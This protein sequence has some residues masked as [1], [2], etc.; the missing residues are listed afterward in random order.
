[1]RTFLPDDPPEPPLVD[2]QHVLDAATAAGSDPGSASNSLSAETNAGGDGRDG[3]SGK[4]SDAAAICARETI[5][6]HT[7]QPTPGTAMAGSNGG[8]S[9][10]DN[11]DGVV[12]PGGG[13]GSSSRGDFFWDEAGAGGRGLVVSSPKDLEPIFPPSS[14]GLATSTALDT[15]AAAEGASATASAAA[16]AAAAANGSSASAARTFVSM[17][18][19]TLPSRYPMGAGGS[20][21]MGSDERLWLVYDGVSAAGKGVISRVNAPDPYWLGRPSPGAVCPHAHSMKFYSSFESANL[22]R[23]VQVGMDAIYVAERICW[24]MFLVLVPCIWTCFTVDFF[25]LCRRRRPR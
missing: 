12:S 11:G 19:G 1:M 13:G 17:G 3:R 23:A 20:G 24:R 7:R 22:L 10:G 9:S 8:G 15:A 25:L 14:T 16:A 4:V 5:P 2:T 18:T 6:V 21:A